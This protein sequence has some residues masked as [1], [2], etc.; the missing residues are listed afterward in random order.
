MFGLA[1]TELLAELLQG[2]RLP[3]GELPLRGEVSFAPE[4][5]LRIG[6]TVGQTFRGSVDHAEL[7]D[8]VLHPACDVGQFSAI[9]CGLVG[10]DRGLL[11]DGCDSLDRS[12]NLHAGFGLPFGQFGNSLIHLVDVR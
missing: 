6:A 3:L 7:A 8:Q 5:D 12:A 9:T 1:P 10:A 2:E 11:C 4:I